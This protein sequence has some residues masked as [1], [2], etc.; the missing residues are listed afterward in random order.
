MPASPK[1]VSKDFLPTAWRESVESSKLPKL[2]TANCEVVTIKSIGPLLIGFGYLSVR[3]WFGIVEN[4]AVDDML[5]ASFIDRVIRGTFLTERKIISCHSRPV[6]NMITKAAINLIKSDD[7][8][9]NVNNSTHND[10]WKDE[11]DLRWNA[12]QKIITRHTPTT[13]LVSCQNSRLMK[14]KTH[15]NVVELLCSM[16]ARDLKK[17]LPAEPVYVYIANLTAKSFSMLKLMI[18]ISTSNALTCI[19]HARD[20]EPYMLKDEGPILTRCDKRV[21]HSTINAVCYKLLEHGDGQMDRHNAEKHSNE[22]SKTNCR[23]NISLPDE[24]S[25]YRGTFINMLIQSE[26]LWDEHLGSIKLVQH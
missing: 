7:K 4:L 21:S 14:I 18:I 25:V 22:I 2:W 1:L 10:A 11:Y 24:Y 16:S 26:S 12:R 15:V 23:K 19:K 17:I 20:D 9:L 13:V 8:I 6:T 3:T 5:G